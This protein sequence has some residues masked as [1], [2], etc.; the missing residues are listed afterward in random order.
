MPL[1]EFS[2]VES[3]NAEHQGVGR[4]K[5]VPADIAERSMSFE[6]HVTP[7]RSSPVDSTTDRF[8]GSGA[9]HAAASGRT[10][11]PVALSLEKARIDNVMRSSTHVVARNSPRLDKL[12]RLKVSPTANG[13]G[14][15]CRSAITSTTERR[16]AI[17]ARH[18]PNPHDSRGRVL[19]GLRLCTVDAVRVISCVFRCPPRADSE[20]RLQLV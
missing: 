7:R 12:R 6:V 4:V 5:Q 16:V 1:T 10:L 2:I 3:T 8:S 9:E 14:G 18:P 20:T 11:Q 13:E 17:E 19:D 15:L